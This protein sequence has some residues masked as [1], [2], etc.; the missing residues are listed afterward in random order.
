MHLSTLMFTLFAIGVSANYRCYCTNG[1]HYREQATREICRQM[2]GAT[3]VSV[4]GGD[5]CQLSN[6]APY[7]T[8]WE[9]LCKAHMS[10]DD[11]KCQWAQ[12]YKA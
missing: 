1:G 2:T 10:A 12:S 6:H 4:H 3:M 9:R 5:E 11:G 7:K 8:Q